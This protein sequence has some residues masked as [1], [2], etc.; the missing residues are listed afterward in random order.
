MQAPA[1]FLD[2]DDL[3]TTANNAVISSLVLFRR[4]PLQQQASILCIV[5]FFKMRFY[6]DARF[7]T[8]PANKAALF[9]KPSWARALG[10]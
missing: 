6:P 8:S 4:V 10:G 3:E 7:P 9:V 2:D 5:H 1:S